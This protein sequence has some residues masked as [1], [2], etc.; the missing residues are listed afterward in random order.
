M[1]I[2]SDTFFDDRAARRN[3]VIYIVCALVVAGCAATFFV[4]S[5]QGGDKRPVTKAEAQKPAGGSTKRD[6]SAGTATIVSRESTDDRPT[7]NLGGGSNPDLKAADTGF[8]AA[9]ALLREARDLGPGSEEGA[10]L[11][12]R[13]LAAF[14]EAQKVYEAWLEA[15]PEDEKR[16]AARL[17]DIRRQVFW[18]RK[19]MPATEFPDHGGG[20]GG[21]GDEGDAPPVEPTRPVDIPRPEPT[22]PDP[23]IRPDRLLRRYTA[24]VQR[25]IREGRPRAI[26]AE[27]RKLLEDK[28]LSENHDRIRQNVEQAETLVAF[29]DAATLAL[30]PKIGQTI[31]LD[32]RKGTVT[33]VLTAT[34]PDLT[35]KIGEKE[36]TYPVSDLSA[37]MLLALAGE[38]EFLTSGF[39]HLAAA[40]YLF[41]RGDREPAFE[42]FARARAEGMD[43][44]SFDKPFQQALRASRP[45]QALAAWVELEPKLGEKTEA[46]LTLITEFRRK[47]RDSAIF[48]A[49]RERMFSAAADAVG[50]RPFK[51]E[52]LFSGEAKLSGRGRIKLAY[53]FDAPEQ[54][55]DFEQRGQWRVEGGSL[56]GD[57]GTIWIEKFD[58]EN[59]D[60]EFSLPAPMPVTI[61]LWARDRSGNGAVNLKVVPDAGQ[62]KI[63][64]RHGNRP[65]GSESIR[66]PSGRLTFSIQRRDEKYQV[67]LNRKVIIKGTDLLRH[68]SA[69][70]HA[71]GISARA[72]P[73]EIDGL[74][75]ATTL[76][77]GWARAGGNRFATWIREWYVT[78]PFAVREK[79]KRLALIK[80]QWPETDPFNPL[81]TGEDG[82]KLWYFYPS[83]STWLDLNVLKPNRNAGAYQA[84]RVWSPAKRTAVLE[85]IADDSARAW[86]NGSLVIKE[87][88]LAKLQ[89]STV[90]LKPGDNILIVKVLQAGGAW[91]SATRFLTKDGGP[92]RDLQYW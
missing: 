1:G 87:A 91:Y 29:L 44:G 2:K 57:K 89:R 90:K 38:A 41:H 48:H 46:V 79:S 61:G 40:A 6:D 70:L 73:V 37:P 45:L 36:S 81:A 71:V 84:I 12:H 30:T 23:V 58:L 39:G 74:S 9:L 59:A 15:H 60:L 10:K 28:R 5:G 26:V 35:L 55:R 24:L 42:Q 20:G 76:D 68:T 33:G 4:I 14:L 53:D 52:N 92:M 86:L 49:N 51:V 88:P 69:D 78:V 19:N 80:E 63:D 27:G 22:R 65:I 50:D 56:I 75:I 34:G 82:K 7:S 31:A 66:M 18:T 83:K 17:A 8:E 25:A 11:K 72:G 77:V 62:L 54:I 67:R 16:Y 32:L 43:L 85:L 47:H 21:G 3:R 13:A 64:L